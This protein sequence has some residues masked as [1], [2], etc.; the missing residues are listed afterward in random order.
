MSIEGYIVHKIFRNGDDAEF[1]QLYEA[2]K[3]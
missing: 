1:Y 3:V 2:V